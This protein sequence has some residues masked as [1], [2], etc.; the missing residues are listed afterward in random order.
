MAKWKLISSK[1]YNSLEYGAVYDEDFKSK[2]TN[3]TI[4][5]C[6]VLYPGDWLRV[7]DEFVLPEKWYIKGC[8]SMATW[9]MGEM[10]DECDEA[11]TWDSSFYVLSDKSNMIKWKQTDELPKGHTEITYDQ[12]IKYVYEPWKENKLRKETEESLSRVKPWPYIKDT[13]AF[14]A[15]QTI[16]VGKPYPK[17]MMVWDNGDEE[18]KTEA[19]VLLS[20]NGKFHAVDKADYD[21][22]LMDNSSEDYG[23]YKWDNAEDIQE[24]VMYKC[25]YNKGVRCPMNDC[26]NGCE[27]WKPEVF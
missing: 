8:A 3:L 14:V 7:E 17:W 13:S 25:P 4:G 16:P 24:P 21:H 27:N 9:Q 19:Y 6:A 2:P 5:E 23:V 1:N 10:N 12:F 20:F 18:S 15:N 11:F 22:L 26:C